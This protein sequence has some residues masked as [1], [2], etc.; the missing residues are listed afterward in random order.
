LIFN[1]QKSNI[2]L[3]DAAK[4]TSGS[5]VRGIGA[6]QVVRCDHHRAFHVDAIGST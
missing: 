3:R 1:Q 2:F 4:A 5:T 6:Q